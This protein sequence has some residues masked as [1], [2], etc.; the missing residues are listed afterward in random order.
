MWHH[1]TI[2]FW[3]IS[4]VIACVLPVTLAASFLIVHSYRQNTAFV[5][6]STMATSRALIQAVDAELHG[7]QSALQA[8]ATSPH[9]AA[10]DLAGFYRQSREALSV[11]TGSNV[12]L[13]D[14]AAQQVL[15]T[16]RPFGTAL[17][18]HGQP[19]VVR[20]ILDTGEPVISDLFLGPV[21][22]NWVIAVEVPVRVDGKIIYT[23]AMGVTP[24]RLNDIL[25]R[26]NIPPNWVAAIFDGTG[27]IVA[28]TH[29][30]DQ[31]VGKK[32]APEFIR[33]FIEVA[34]ASVE[35][36]TVE[37]IP[38]FS[39]FSRSPRSGWTVGMG[40]PIA[41]LAAN[42]RQSIVFNAAIAVTLL[43]LG[44]LAAA[45]FGARISRS[46][47]SLTAP[48]LALGSPGSP[49]IP[50]TEIIEVD[51]VGQALD[52]ASHLIAERERERAQREADTRK[53]LVAKQVAE[54]ANR[55]KSEF[56][57]SMSHELRTPLTAISGF[58]QLLHRSGGTLAR[59]R[60]IR[61]TE[62]I[63][64]ASEH[65]ENIINDVLDMARLESGH[66]KLDL[67]TLDC[68]EIMTEASRTLELQ[69][70]KSGIVFTVD[71]SANLPL[72]T[73]DRTR[74]I[75]VLLN[76]GSNAIKYNV[77]DGWVQL[78][79]IPVDSMVRFIVRD[80][81]PGIAPEL[82]DQ[83]FQPFN[84]LGAELTQIEGT[85]IGL[86]LSRRLVLAMNGR[87][88]FESTVGQGS[89]FWVDLPAADETAAAA[90]RIATPRPA[91]ASDARTTVLYVE[92]KIPN[93]E[94]MRGVVEQAG[95]IRLLDAQTVKDGLAI[96]RSMKP[97]LVITDIHLPDGKGYDVLQGLREDPSTAHIPVVALTA[98]AM[99]ANMDNMRR[100][101]FD[102][103]V[104]KP[105]KIA[106]LETLLRNRLQPAPAVKG[107]P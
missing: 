57:A 29:A 89:K 30:P 46:I 66:V 47:R 63:M 52:R 33:R 37:G 13:S 36:T 43:A 17:P 24:E 20:R 78:S 60:R 81:G 104:T 98:D 15:N 88:G 38:I 41:D 62:N 21:V 75:Q 83:I 51:E 28:R 22:S 96:A 12:V 64:Q 87:I 58:A 85:G 45:V 71:T 3:L 76:L 103:I 53:A 82:R 68:L 91:T 26:Q 94:L 48:A 92:D 49:S 93:V 74:L 54:E 107:S 61:Y 5:G 106:E 95:G 102:H 31:F 84:R 32:G 8:L 16:L 105:F 55:A 56:L 23:L 39:S 25:R 4:L 2:R 70:R 99:P 72:V 6:Q 80:T 11:L 69:A 14:P 44:C 27:T 34:E 97:D 42:A 79:A 7:V 100:A 67:E 90:P 18:R 59:E 40:I 86:A 10:G 77:S 19:D 9:L 73:A 1:K 50:V 35:T 65:L 101:G